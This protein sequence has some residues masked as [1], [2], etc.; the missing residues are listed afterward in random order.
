MSKALLVPG[1]TLA[2]EGAAHNEHGHV[3]VGYTGYIHRGGKGR[4]KCSCGE[5]SEVLDSGKQ[6]QQWHRDHKAQIRA[7]S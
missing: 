7:G 2:Y 5:M 6:R 3:I 4:G 1:H